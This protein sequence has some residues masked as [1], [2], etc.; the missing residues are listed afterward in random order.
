MCV[1]IID[2]YVL[3]NYEKM[4]KPFIYILSNPV[5]LKEDL[6]F[7]SPFFWFVFAKVFLFSNFKTLLRPEFWMDRKR[8]TCIWKV[9]VSAFF[10]MFSYPSM[11]ST[12][13]ELFTFV[14]KKIVQISKKNFCQI[15]SKYV[16][17]KV[18]FLALS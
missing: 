6:G 10:T 1:F 8:A 13:G 11:T 18:R 9:L 4:N 15:Q 2:T 14:R 16:C 17:K 12:L 5:N 7:F 3:Y